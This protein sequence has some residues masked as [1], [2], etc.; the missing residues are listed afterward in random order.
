MMKRRNPLIA[1]LPSL[2]WTVASIV[3]GFFIS[4][5][6]CLVIGDESAAFYFSAFC[7]ALYAPLALL[8]WFILAVRRYI[9]DRRAPASDPQT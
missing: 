6:I 2:G 9:K 4:G 3:V 5:I 8:T 7:L 1:S